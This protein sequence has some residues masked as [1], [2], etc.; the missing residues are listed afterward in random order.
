M[1]GSPGATAVGA[2]AAWGGRGGEGQRTGQ[3][4]TLLTS[5]IFKPQMEGC[6]AESPR[7][8]PAPAAP[9][10]TGEAGVSAE[11]P[12]WATAAQN[13]PLKAFQHLVL[14]EP[15]AEG[16]GSATCLGE[17][18]SLLGIQRGPCP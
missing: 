12:S 8:A 6:K 7:A 9:P 18:R 2:E 17:L 5:C 3:D 13:R 11:G 15:R 14:E 1:C 16:G 4:Q 10:G